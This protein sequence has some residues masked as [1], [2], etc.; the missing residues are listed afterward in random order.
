MRRTIYTEDHQSFRETIRSFIEKEV[1]PVYDEW[2]E[3]GIVPHDFYLKL[4]EL[5]VWGI[6]VPEEY[7]GAG[8]ESFKYSAVMTEELSR[9]GVSFGGSSVHVG[10]CLPYLL[11]LGTKE[12]MERWMPGFVAGEEMWAIAM[13][14]P[15]TGSDL[16]GM[17]T[18]AKLTEDGKH[19]VLNG[20]K[21]FITGGVNADRVVVC[22]RTAP[23]SA[24][25]RRGGITLLAV[26]T[27]LPGYEVGRKLDKLGLK[28]SDTAEL[29][30]TDVQV[31][32]EDVL[33]E[34]GKG[35]SYL[36]QNLPVERLGIAVGAYAQAAAAVEFAKKYVAERKVFGT[37]V[38]SFQN[39]KFEL[40]ACKAE[41]DA[42]EAVVDRAIEAEDL[43]T[44]TAAEAASAK[45]FCTEVAHRVIDRC[46]QLHG[47]YGYMNE[48]PIARLYADNRVNRIYGGTSEVM[49]LIIAKDMGL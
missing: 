23:A 9:A 4:G 32:V 19:Y 12:Q 37:T 11:N 10:L 47:G 7:G 27:S 46:L 17:T 24:D 14:E 43:G 18:N 16:A 26:D 1:T 36:G 3:A 40:A 15:G 45:L 25:D 44:L 29:S 39:T 22:A 42:A 33:G 2:Y 48:Y 41:V 30:F 31:P 13:T 6:Q 8:I 20:A 21:T 49:K 34:V 28:V 38:A 35:F 5:G